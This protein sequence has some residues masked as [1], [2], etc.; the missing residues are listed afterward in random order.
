MPNFYFTSL[1]DEGNGHFDSEHTPVH[2]YCDNQSCWCHY[3]VAYHTQVQH[4]TNQKCEECGTFH[5]RL[6]VI[7][8]TLLCQ[9]CALRVIH[10]LQQQV[11]VQR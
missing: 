9:A 3:N 4:P 7:F 5:T 1:V 10:E 8:Q 11:E 2:P 6:V